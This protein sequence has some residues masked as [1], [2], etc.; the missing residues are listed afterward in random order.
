[1]VDRE[2]DEDGPDSLGETVW[3]WVGLGGDVPQPAVERRP[4]ETDIGT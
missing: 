4:F 3:L 1:M 2:D